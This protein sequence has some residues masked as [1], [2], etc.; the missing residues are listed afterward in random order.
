MN[1]DQLHVHQVKASHGWSWI[2]KG[3]ALFRLNPVMWIL[4]FAI[5]LL[6]AMA[7][8]YINVV[9]PL[10]LNLLAPVFVGG[11]MFG[12]RAL[13]NGEQLELNHLF[14][15]FKQHTAN[16]IT[17]GGIY[18]TGILLV[19]S[20]MFFSIGPDA[21]HALTSGDELTSQQ[22]EAILGHGFYKTLLIGLLLIVPLVMSY[23]FAPTLIIFNELT[24]VQAMRQSFLAC[25]ENILPFMVYGFI[26]MVLL[27]LAIIPL[28]LGL[29]LMIPVMTASI[30]TSY[31]DIFEDIPVK[32]KS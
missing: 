12:C 22:A 28:G 8:S 26:T 30:Y 27:M 25:V 7:L 6:I 9:G 24:A 31:S 17:V 4:M 19:M 16:L 20:V 1:N 23:W 5:Y 21:M 14:A 18:M 11:F 3:F 29:L 15:G 10:V 32:A 13:D 2:A